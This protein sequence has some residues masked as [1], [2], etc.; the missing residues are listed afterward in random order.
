VDLII[1]GW[2]CQGFSAAGFGEGLSDIRSGLFTDMVRLIT[3]AQSI[4][5]SLG[6][7]IENTPSQLDQRE[8]YT[9]VRHYLGEP[10][11]LDAAQCGSYAHQLCNWWTNLA[12]LSVLQLALKYTIRNPNLQV[13]HILD[14]QSSCQPV[15]RQEK[16]LWF[17]LNTIGKPRGP[18][19][20]FV[21]FPRAHAFQKDEPGLVYH[22]ALAT[23]NE[24]SPEERERA[25]GFQTGTTSLTKVTRL[26]RNAL[27]GRGMDLNSLTWLLVTCVFFH[28]YTTP[29]IIQSTCNF[30]DAT[31]WHP[32]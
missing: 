18:W 14:D 9:L 16:P 10:F 20:T 23:W 3:W 15:T 22:H 13:S 4:S 24:P 31:T 26:E 28:M 30:G 32:D 8:H 19:P 6:Y 7:V 27:L 21:S 12:P 17:P 25:M 29:T 5:P 11:L 2:E 1:S